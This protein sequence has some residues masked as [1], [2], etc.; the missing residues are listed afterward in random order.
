MAL[1]AHVTYP[2][3]G[4]LVL[5]GDRTTV[6]ELRVVF[7][8]WSEDDLTTSF[9]QV[10]Q[11][12][13]TPPS[14]IIDEGEQPFF[15]DGHGNNVYVH[16]FHVPLDRIPAGNYLFTF[17]SGDDGWFYKV[18]ITSIL[19]LSVAKVPGRMLPD[20]H[21]DPARQVSVLLGAGDGRR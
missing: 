13:S 15:G 8:A 17:G 19:T 7:R 18:G 14:G 3:G 9:G 21:L 2:E 20:T 16:R 6:D 11:A 10:A 5:A 1:T 4:S 12:D